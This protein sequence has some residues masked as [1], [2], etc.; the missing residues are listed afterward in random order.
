[1]TNVV[2]LILVIG[3]LY[4]KATTIIEQLPYITLKFLHILA[5]LGL[6][7][8]LSNYNVFCY[9]NILHPGLQILSPSASQLR[10]NRHTRCE[11]LESAPKNIAIV[12]A[13]LA[14]SY[15]LH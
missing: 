5:I 2:S 12:G 13:G 6:H 10:H 15:P 14:V 4:I 11:M 3:N 9:H 8:S 7:H 1:M